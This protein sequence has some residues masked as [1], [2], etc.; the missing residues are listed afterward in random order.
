MYWTQQLYKIKKDDDED[1]LDDEDAEMMALEQTK[2]CMVS[3]MEGMRKNKI[4]SIFLH[5]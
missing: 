1:D 5:T 3:C 2:P 4:W